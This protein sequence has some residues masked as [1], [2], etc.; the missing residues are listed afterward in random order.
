MVKKIVGDIDLEK[1]NILEQRYLEYE[2]CLIN[3]ELFEYKDIYSLISLSLVEK[4]D[5]SIVGTSFV[6]YIHTDIEE[7]FS[8]IYTK[9]P[10]GKGW[11][12]VQFI[13]EIQYISF[14]LLYYRWILEQKDDYNLIYQIISE[15]PENERIF[16]ITTVIDSIWNIEFCDSYKRG[17][18]RKSSMNGIVI[19]NEINERDLL[20]KQLK[21]ISCNDEKTNEFY[22]LNE[23]D[24]GY[25][26]DL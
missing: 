16:Y 13:Q 21:V 5:Y 23:T 10:F 14:S 7:E 15:I 19:I 11:R 24:Q 9:E 8:K 26:I 17:I 12:Y 6:K 20:D 22:C 3:K 18:G 2:D 4:V 25:Y 1:R